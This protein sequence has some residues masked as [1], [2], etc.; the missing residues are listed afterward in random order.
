MLTDP[1]PRGPKYGSSGSRS[2]TLMCTI[3]YVD[4][5]KNLINTSTSKIEYLRFSGPLTVA[6]YMREVLTSP[7][8][9][10]K[11]KLYELSPRL[12]NWTCPIQFCG[13]GS[14]AFLPLY[15]GSGMDKYQDSNP[16]WTTQIIFP[17]VWKQFFGLKYLTPSMWIRDPGFKKFG[18]GINLLNPQHWP[19]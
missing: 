14:G 19:H 3:S 2:A 7:L 4:L 5:I 10:R 15:P 17:R 18:A 13:P 11:K 8:Q 16:G 1:E 12:A 9:A 6:E